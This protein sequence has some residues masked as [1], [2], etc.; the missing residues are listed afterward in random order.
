M[1]VSKEF[2]IANKYYGYKK[3]LLYIKKIV[4]RI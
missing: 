1:V 3:L 4:N 2:D